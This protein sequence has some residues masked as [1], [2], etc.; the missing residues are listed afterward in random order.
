MV[1]I[2]ETIPT[3]DNLLRQAM[4]IAFDG[5]CFYTGRDVAFDEMHID[6]IRPRSKGGKDCIA[7]YVLCCQE[8]NLKKRDRHADSFEEVVAETVKLL[9]A[10]RVASVLDDL[11][12]NTGGFVRPNDWLR[13]NG[14]IEHSTEW[15]R[16]RNRIRTRGLH[17]VSRVINGKSRGIVM[18]RRA[19][20][21]AILAEYQGPARNA[22]ASTT[23]TS[24][25]RSTS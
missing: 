21:D 2:F 12:M 13:E 16:L 7:N 4:F 8:I 25:R 24:T 18:Y 3:S 23:A 15:H 14:I 9:F 17:S 10:D 6:H 5:K 1:D 20:L 11:R 22:A 19:D